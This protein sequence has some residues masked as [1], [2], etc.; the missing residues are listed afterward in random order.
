LSVV[1]GGIGA[2]AARAAAAASWPL[3]VIRSGDGTVYLTGETPGGHTDWSDRRIEGLLP[4]CGALWTEAGTEAREPIGPLL[5]RFGVDGKT[6]LSSRFGDEDKARLAKAAAL[7]QFP[8]A[9]LESFR[10]WLAAYQL[11]QAYDRTAGLT[12]RSANEVLVAEAKKAGVP[13]RSE[14]PTQGD[15]IAEYGA[16]SPDQDLQFLRLTLDNILAPPEQVA[17]EN[18]DWARGDVAR[19]AAAADQFRRRY[20]ELARALL[21][22]RNRRWVPRIQA[23][24]QEAKPS[25]VVVGDYHL[26][27][28]EGLLALLKTA[29]LNPRRL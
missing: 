14:F 4:A 24:L 20:P 18:S 11:E 25:L 21:I 6:P 22:E 17:R 9:R 3:W 12:G 13:V 5:A 27:G 19:A 29:G 2:G 23:M 10:P 8:V 26:L 1:V 15:T 28:P 7:A 16:L